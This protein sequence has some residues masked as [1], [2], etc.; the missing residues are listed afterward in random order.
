MPFVPFAATVGTWLGASAAAG[1]AAIAGVTAAVAGGVYSTVSSA[2]QAEQ[3][4]KSQQEALDFQA[5][6]VAAAEAKVKGAEALASQTAADKLKK[7]RL[8]QTQTILSSPLGITENANVTKT[9][10]GVG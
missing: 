5:Q 3:E 7:Q 1:G 2:A 4:K 9:T 6:Q 10:L 8:S